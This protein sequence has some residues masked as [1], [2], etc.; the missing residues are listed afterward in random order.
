MTN[1]T[2]TAG[3]WQGNLK[4]GLA[5]RELEATL[6]AAA[7]LTVKEIGRVMGIS[8]NTAEK[9]LDSARFK[10][11]A[12]TMRGLVME[13][14]KRQIISPLIVLLCMVLT[15]QQAN[16]EQFGRIRR[17]GERRVE[18]RVAVRRIETALTA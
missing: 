4:M 12:K 3:N 13:A 1:N 6:W 5:P 8:P 2:L 10:L 11:G 7:D 14:F 18:T 15:V 9:R 16:T 17:P